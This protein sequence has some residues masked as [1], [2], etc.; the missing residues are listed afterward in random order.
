MRLFWY[1]L[2]PAVVAACVVASVRAS[3]TAGGLDSIQMREDFISG[4]NGSMYVANSAGAGAYGNLQIDA[5]A[6]RPG[7]IELNTGTTAAGRGSIIT[8]AAKGI[9]FGGGEW[10]YEGDVY[11]AGA[12]N[13]VQSFVTRE[14]F[15][16]SYQ[17]APTDGAWVEHND[18][19]SLNWLI[20]T[21]SNGNRTTT[22]SGVAVATGWHRTKIVVAGDGSAA[23]FTMDGAALGTI[24][25]DIPTTPGRMTGVGVGIFKVLGASPRLI[26]VDW[27]DLRVTLTNSR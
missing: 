21:S 23:T 14:G 27:T 16:D 13:Q 8:G 3:D 25:S 9:L 12:S 1:A 22:Q 4:T 20:C 7:L 26:R 10:V 17:F 6:G 2:F 18:A 5:E 11:L 15:I 19:L 24:T